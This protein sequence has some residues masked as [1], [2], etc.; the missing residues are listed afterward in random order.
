MVSG[1]S[2]IRYLY[3][4]Y[5]RL[6]MEYILVSHQNI[7]FLFLHVNI[8]I[9]LLIKMVEVCGYANCY[10]IKIEIYF[11]NISSW[12]VWADYD[13]NCLLSS[14]KEDKWRQT[15]LIISEWINQR[16][17]KN[18]L[19]LHSSSNFAV[20]CLFWFIPWFL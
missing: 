3:S 11:M 1:N 4:I 12:K 13:I 18:P 16:W 9:Y 19:K 7:F 6:N 17:I 2:G 20:Y 15:I 5:Q 14:A 8:S 10:S